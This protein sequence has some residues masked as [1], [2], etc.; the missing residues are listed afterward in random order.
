MIAISRKTET[1][2]IYHT[3]DVHSHFENWPGIQQYLTGKRQEHEQAGD[4]V[5]VFDLGDFVDRSHPFTEATAGRGNTELLNAAQYD[6]VTIGN[7]E[8]ITLP[9]EDLERLYSGAEFD[10]IVANLAEAD[11]TSPDWAV[12]YKQYVTEHGVTVAVIAATAV[13]EAFYTKLG[14][15][16]REPRAIL[17]N[18]AARLRKTSDVVICLSHLGVREDRLLA[19]ETNDIDL[20]LGAHT[21]HL[22]VQ[23]EWEGDTLLAATGKFGQYV[24]RVCISVEDGRI[25]GR[26]ASVIPAG[27]L[28]ADS[29]TEEAFSRK[30]AEGERLLERTAFHLPRTLG[31]NLFGTSALSDFFGQALLTY[32]DAD[33]GLFNAGLFLG[34]LPGG[35][36]TLRDL[37]SVLPHPIN[38]CVLTITGRSLLDYYRISQNP[39]WARTEVRGLGFRGTLMGVM[40]PVNLHMEDGILHIGEER[41]GMQKRYRLATLDMFTFGFFYPNMKYET[42]DYLVPELIRDI[43]GWYGRQLPR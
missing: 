43:A 25:T 4:A 27:E 10:V 19:D 33:C 30:L 40:I 8:G 35:D 6:A 39:D 13:Y 37:H 23:G 34:S 26:T 5:F 18:L 41:V 1:I 11:G 24:G 29:E 12:P 9:K 17:I 3:N 42:I 2:H 7:N 22:F 14:W 15:T 21:H 32:T 31:Q 28:E 16:I 36:V 38:A 20:I